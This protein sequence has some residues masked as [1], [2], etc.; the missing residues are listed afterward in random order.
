MA[1]KPKITFM[2]HTDTY[3]LSRYIDVTSGFNL[4]MGKAKKV[5]GMYDYRT[6]QVLE[7]SGS[8]IQFC[9]DNDIELA[10]P[11]YE[12]KGSKLPKAFY[13]NFG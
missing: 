12:T 8:A 1:D 9:K 4:C 7:L 5:Y 11:K 2:I 10:P 6:E 13:I 3:G